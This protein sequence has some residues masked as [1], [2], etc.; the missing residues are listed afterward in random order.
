M[1]N[2][3]K[4]MTNENEDFDSINEEEEEVEVEEEVEDIEEDDKSLALE[5]KVK[6][7]EAQKLHWKKKATQPKKEEAKSDGLSQKDLYAL[8]NNK[9]HEDDVD[10]VAEYAKLKN[11]DIKEA[12]QSNVIKTILREKAEE[13]KTQEVSNTGTTRKTKTEVD[14]DTLIAKARK[15]EGSESKEDMV[16]MF[17]KVAGLK[18]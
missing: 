1:N 10:D 13:R 17:N 14:A 5:K 15:G 2:K 3:T 9:V 18:D 4:L 12:L 16:R 6:E 8:M 7:L 11:I